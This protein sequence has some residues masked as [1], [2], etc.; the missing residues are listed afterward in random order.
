M[1]LLA[2]IPAV[3]ALRIL[4]LAS[5]LALLFAP[6]KA[7]RFLRELEAAPDVHGLRG[8]RAVLC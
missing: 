1:G 5:A 7:E 2:N 3:Q 8:L 6:E 4:E